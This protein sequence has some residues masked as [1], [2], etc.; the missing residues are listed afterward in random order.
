M[1]I[2]DAQVHSCN[3]FCHEKAISIR[4]AKCVSVTSDIQHAKYM[5]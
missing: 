3:H 1:Y 2:H 5:C 4:Y